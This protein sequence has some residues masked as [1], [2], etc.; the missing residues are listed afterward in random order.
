MEAMFSKTDEINYFQR[1]TYKIRCE[2]ELKEPTNIEVTAVVD[3][4]PG[5]NS[6]LAEILQ[7]AWRKALNKTIGT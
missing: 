5:P 7:I 3:I 4:G 2:A 1:R 6:I